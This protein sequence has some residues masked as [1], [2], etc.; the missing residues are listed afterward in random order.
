MQS[1]FPR[2]SDIRD[3]SSGRRF[4]RIRK[5]EAAI[6]ATLLRLTVEKEQLV[7]GTQ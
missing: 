1:L 7:V 5:G 4:N 3:I 6:L 2:C